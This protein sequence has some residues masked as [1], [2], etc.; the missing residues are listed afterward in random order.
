MAANQG[1]AAAQYELGL[2]Y[3]SKEGVPQDLS[4]CLDWWLKAATQ[5][6]AD[7]CFSLG[8]LF[9]EAAK[10]SPEAYIQAYA[11]FAAASMLDE[12]PAKIA[13][14]LAARDLV[15]KHMSPAQIVE[16]EKIVRQLPWKK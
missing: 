6:Y 2:A 3:F 7:A 5:G 4:K 12:D 16:A 15:A 10:S 13:E 14:S 9:N 11:F 8:S 1:H